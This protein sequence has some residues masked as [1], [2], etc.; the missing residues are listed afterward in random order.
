[1]FNYPHFIYSLIVTDFWNK[2]RESYSLLLNLKPLPQTGVGIRHHA[3]GTWPLRKDPIPLLQEAGWASGLGW[4]GV[5][6][7]PLP[8]FKPRTLQPLVITYFSLLSLEREF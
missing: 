2:E 7:L 8:G 5:E 3:P 4:T 1:M 6:N